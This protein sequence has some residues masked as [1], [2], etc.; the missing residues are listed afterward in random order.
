MLLRTVRKGMNLL[1][2]KTKRERMNSIQ[3]IEVFKA[4]IDRERTR[5]DRNSHEFSLVVFKFSFINT[6]SS[7]PI[8]H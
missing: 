3:S 8:F 6:R 1:N 2:G 5:C 7:L 4:L